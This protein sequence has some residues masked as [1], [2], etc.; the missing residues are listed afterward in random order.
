MSINRNIPPHFGDIQMPIVPDYESATLPNGVQMHVL[1]GGAQP[2]VKVDLLVKAG[3]LRSDKP[4]VARAV[5]N[6]IAEGT[7]SHTSK[8]I[9]Q[10]IDFYGAGFWNSVSHG[11]TVISLLCLSRDVAN[12]LPLVEEIIKEPTFPKEEVDLYVAQEVQSFDVNILKSSFVASRAMLKALY[13]DDDRHSRIAM[14]EDYLNLD[15][16]ALKQFHSDTYRPAGA[17]VLV[18]GL[19]SEAD[20]RIIS[21]AFG[22]RWSGG[23]DWKAFVP[24]FNSEVRRDFIDFDAKQTSLRMTRRVFNRNEPDYLT[25]QVANV[26]LG[27]YFGSRL[28][29]TLRE[30]LGLTYGVS[31]YIAANS[32]SGIHCISSE[33]KSGSHLQAIDVINGEME[34]LTTELVSDKELNSIRGFMLGDILRYF[35]SVTTSADTLLSFLMDDVP[36]SHVAEFYNV[37]KNISPSEIREVARRWLKPELYN[38]ICVGKM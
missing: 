3:S 4:L 29:Q 28:M 36:A 6:L 11:N 1:R 20:I 33:V 19:P 14:R 2:L 21:D 7:R 30:K 10:K 18:S 35:D 34:R 16:Q 37:V 25:F 13:A 24:R 32:L 22:S 27:G 17:H 23:Q 31:S 8:D 26:A 15:S 9:A 5:A 12:V 38:V